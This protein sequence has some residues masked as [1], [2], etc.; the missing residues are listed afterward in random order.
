L[1]QDK[2]AVRFFP[3]PRDWP[4]DYVWEITPDH[5]NGGLWVRFGDFGLT[6]FRDGNWTDP[7]ASSL[8]EIRPRAS[9]ADS[10][11]RTWFGHDENRVSMLDGDSL[12]SYSKTDGINIGIVRVIR[13]KGRDI[14]MGGDS[15]LAVFEK[16]RFWTV[17]TVAGRRFD[18]VTGI[19]ETADGAL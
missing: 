7:N 16:G 18:T 13:G 10:F 9:F 3:Q 6:H 17:R 19:V 15:G 8:A 4:I 2:N 1:R 5:R 11:G 14:W 12:R